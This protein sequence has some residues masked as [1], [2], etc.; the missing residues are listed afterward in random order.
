M[1]V[2]PAIWPEAAHEG[3]LGK[4]SLRAVPRLISTLKALLLFWHWVRIPTG[5][6]DFYDVGKRGELGDS[7]QIH[8]C[9]PTT[10]SCV[11]YGLGIT[12]PHLNH[13]P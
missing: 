9:L 2:Q 6:V 4:S 3:S 12:S 10:G 8:G 11:S 7:Q 5:D 1:Q 13:N